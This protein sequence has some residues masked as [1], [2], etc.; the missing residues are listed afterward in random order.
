MADA[1]CKV[2]IM[3]VEPSW[4]SLQQVNEWIRFADAK[5][6]AVLAGS[7]I[8]GGFLVRAIPRLDDFQR[9]TTRAVLLSIA[10]VS[11]GVSSSIT[12]RVL[13]PRLR[14]GEA[15]S[16]IYFDHIARRYP[17]DRNAF[18]EN[19]LH[20]AD[21]E[22]DLARRTA[23]QVWATSL[24][25]RRKFRR[26]SYAIASLGLAMASSGLAVLVERLWNW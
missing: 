8:L 11:V 14:T 23:E 2:S 22:T 21:N 3:A 12:L 20:L 19:F 18:I 9:Y 4:K 5:A 24:V 26:V 25:A 17:K 6:G 15:R 1:R 16:L 13:A 7:G 10:I